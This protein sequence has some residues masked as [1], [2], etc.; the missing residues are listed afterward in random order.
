MALN[1]A[2]PGEVVDLRPLA[3]ELKTARTAALEG[4]DAVRREP[5]GRKRLPSPHHRLRLARTAHDLGSPAAIGGRR[6]MLARH[7]ASAAR[8]DP[9]PP[10]QAGGGPLA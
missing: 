4:P 7:T 6:M 1:H 2:A 10:P 9:R 3:E 8:C 5:M